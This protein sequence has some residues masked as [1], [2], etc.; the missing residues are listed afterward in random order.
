MH[1]TVIVR[2]IYVSL[3]LTVDREQWKKINKRSAKLHDDVDVDVGNGTVWFGLVGLLVCNIAKQ[4][5]NIFIFVVCV[6][7]TRHQ[8][9]HIHTHTHTHSMCVSVSAFSIHIFIFVTV[10]LVVAVDV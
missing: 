3:A 2:Y 9:P 10:G 8:S 5:L 7:A 1:E 6:A 4:H